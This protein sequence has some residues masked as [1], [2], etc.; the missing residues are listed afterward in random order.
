MI[1]FKNISYVLNFF[2]VR[3]VIRPLRAIISHRG[4]I[5][6]L[7]IVTSFIFFS[8]HRTLSSDKFVEKNIEQVSFNSKTSYR[9][10]T[11]SFTY[12]NKIAYRFFSFALSLFIC[13]ALGS[14]WM[15]FSIFL[16]INLYLI[17]L[18]NHAKIVVIFDTVPFV[19]DAIMFVGECVL[20]STR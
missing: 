18:K 14:L 5:F 2:F 13:F 7:F 12:I 17:L 10:H 3:S 6:I 11:R 20:G 19:T 1:I 16:S 15:W 8:V 9:F 4:A